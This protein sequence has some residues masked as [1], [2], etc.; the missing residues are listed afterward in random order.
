MKRKRNLWIFIGVL[1]LAATLV[2]GF[3]L[4]QATAEDILVQALE[5]AETISDGRAVIAIDVERIDKKTSAT[6]EV[7][8]RHSEDSGGEHNRDAFRIKVLETSEK[9]AQEAIIVSDGDTLWA[10]SP[11]KNEVFI[12]TPEEAQA[13]MEGR[14]YLG[15]GFLD[16]LDRFHH[17]GES[18]GDDG[19]YEHPQNAEEIVAKLQEYFHIGTSSNETFAGE[20][21]DQIELEPIPEQMPS[22]Y[23]AVGGIVNLW[24]GQESNLPLAVAYT[25]GSVGE[26]T[27]TVLEYEVNAG[28]DESL[29]T[30]EIPDGVEV[31]TFADL[32]PQSLTLEEAG[33]A[34]EFEFLMP[35]EIPS[36]AT[37]VDILDVRGALVQR[38]TLPQGGSFTIAQGIYAQ[39]ST[40]T[41]TTSAK[42]QTVDV[43]GTPGQLFADESGVKVLLTWSEGEVFYSLAGN[44]TAE[45][46]LTIAESL[47]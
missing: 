6:I 8:A 42:S 14:D 5:T 39:E 37:L 31:V 40:A 44:L 11:A 4:T 46:A 38:Y 29:F 16:G 12:G 1:I 25:G 28:L 15:G 18:K 21:A 43:R 32:K 26:F 2:S 35:T 30:F 17:D 47:Q 9:K 13:M 34:A 7:W 3:V 33:Q 45:Q 22:E 24:I 19:G 20:T 10:Y 41:K 27:A 23:A 36:G